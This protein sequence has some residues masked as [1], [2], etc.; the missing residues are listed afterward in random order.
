MLNRRHLKLFLQGAVSVVLLY[1]VFR[2]LA[3][4]KLGQILAGMQFLWFLA[5]IGLYWLNL[6]CSAWR[7]V[8]V[9]QS[10]ER[11]MP[12]PLLLRLTGIGAF[13]NQVLPGAVSGDAVR[14]YLSKPYTHSLALAVAAVFGERLIGL[15]V[16]IAVATVAFLLGNLWLTSLPPVGSLLGLLL[17]AYLAGMAV[18]LWLRLDVITRWAGRLGEKVCEARLALAS[19]LQ[20]GT[21]LWR[22]LVFSLLVQLISIAM[23]AVLGKALGVQLDATAV[24]VIWPLVSLLTVLPVA[25]GGWGLREGLLVHF[26]AYSGVA[27]EQAL[28][29]SLLL[30]FVVLLAS[31]PGGL[32]WLSLDRRQEV[33]ESLAGQA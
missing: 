17:M 33:P 14:A 11:P 16:L 23:F 13:F 31:L 8:Y 12:Y 10:L 3:W 6:A 32:L 9:M 21:L 18:L 30:G 4:Q 7:S 22:V 27:A 5:G 26:L 28:A 24:W 19:M 25:L 29:L 15:G 2:D 20:R 1:W